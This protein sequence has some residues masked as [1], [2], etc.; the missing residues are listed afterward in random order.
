[1]IYFLF[2][3]LIEKLTQHATP[4]PSRLMVYAPSAF[5]FAER[6]PPDRG[7]CPG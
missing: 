4:E 3:L 1:M 2:S 7:R 5:W 6:H